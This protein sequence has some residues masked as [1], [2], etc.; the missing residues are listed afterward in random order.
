[1]GKLDAQKPLGKASWWNSYGKSD[2]WMAD[3]SLVRECWMTCIWWPTLI[4]SVFVDWLDSTVR[5]RD[6]KGAYPSRKHVRESWSD[7]NLLPWQLGCLSWTCQGLIHT[8]SDRPSY[9]LFS[10]KICNCFC[11]YL[12]LFG[13]THLDP[14]TTRPVPSQRTEEAAC[15]YGR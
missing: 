6:Q 1:M 2:T 13:G 7:D 3:P 10:S 5:R 4:S 12:A 9:G 8:Q 15:K 14:V 11:T